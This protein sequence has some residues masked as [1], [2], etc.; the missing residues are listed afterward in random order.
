MKIFLRTIFTFLLIISVLICFAYFFWYKPKF[1]STF[2]SHKNTTTKKSKEFKR[3]EERSVS[4]KQFAIA[5]RSNTSLAFL[6]DMSLGSGKNR[7]FVYDMDKDSVLKEGLV[8]HGSCDAGF[9]TD[10]AF[11]NTINSG[12]SA[13]GKYRIGSAYIGRFGLAYR[14]YGL[15]SSN[16]NALQRNIV[17]HSYDC[18]P[19]QETD[20]LPICNSRGC[21]MTSPGFLKQ[22]KP[23]IDHSKKPLLLWMFE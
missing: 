11:S 6:I 1:K 7:F 16:K 10:P 17:L 22:L 15:D 19:E 21:P 9:Q 18:V 8:A 3:L 4:L 13:L 14:L 2:N 5:H 20:P 12:C 23:I